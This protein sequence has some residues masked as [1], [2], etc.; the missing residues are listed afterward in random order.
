MCG[1]KDISVD[2]A[3]LYAETT[4]LEALKEGVEESGTVERVVK[5]ADLLGYREIMS[6]S[7]TETAMIEFRNCVAALCKAEVTME[8]AVKEG[9]EL[10]G[11]I[12][13]AVTLLC[14]TTR[15]IGDDFVLAEPTKKL[16]EFE[17]KTAK[18]HSIK[19]KVIGHESLKSIKTSSRRLRW[20]EQ[21]IV[22]L[23][24]PRHADAI[25]KDFGLEHGNSVQT[26]AVFEMTVEEEP[27]PS[28]Q[29]QHHWY[30]SQ[31]VRCLIFSKNRADIKFIVNELCQEMSNPRTKKNIDEFGAMIRCRGCNALKENARARAPSDRCRMRIEECL[32][33]A[34]QGAERLDRKDEV[35]NETLAGKMWRG[36]RSEKRSNETTAAA[37]E[38]GSE[39]AA[40]TTTVTG[41]AAGPARESSIEPDANPKEE[42]AHEV[43]AVD[44]QQQQ[45]AKTEEVDPT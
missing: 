36:E 22:C 32:R 18:V 20:E 9:R 16:M 12:E 35:I 43:S 6:K 15:T 31:V 38:T 23:Y 11:P 1:S 37:Q 3:D 41:P 45:R 40:V 7:D 28:S 19:A 26:S 4:P 25:M 13:N 8:D 5:L 30:R 21:G 39:T 42:T 27:E 33:N 29:D 14:G 10:D 17:E 44:S 34:A 24:G 2:Q